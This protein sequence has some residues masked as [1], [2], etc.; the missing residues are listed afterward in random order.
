MKE[1]LSL[2]FWIVLMPVMSK[3]FV[4]IGADTSTAFLLAVFW[5]LTLLLVL[6]IYLLKFLIVTGL[7][8]ANLF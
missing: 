1:F 5:P 2:V 3:F 4:Y 7:W 6:N 8:F